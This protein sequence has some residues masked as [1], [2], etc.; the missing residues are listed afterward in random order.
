M[1]CLVST[2]ILQLAGFPARWLTFQPASNKG[3]GTDLIIIHSIYCSFSVLLVHKVDESAT[4]KFSLSVLRKCIDQTASCCMARKQVLELLVRNL[5]ICW[6]VS[7]EDTSLVDVAFPR[8][9]LAVSCGDI[10][11]C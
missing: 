2:S 7:D 11:I 3:T 1:R 5:G 4:Q 10:R 9:A 8:S 6:Q